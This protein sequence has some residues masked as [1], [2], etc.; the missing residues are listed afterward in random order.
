VAYSPFDQNISLRVGKNP[1]P[2]IVGIAITR[3]IFIGR[4]KDER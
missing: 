2:I 4:G 3:N 1:D